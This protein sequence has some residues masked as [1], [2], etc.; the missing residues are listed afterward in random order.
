MPPTSSP[1]L[2]SAKFPLRQRSASFSAQTTLAGLRRE[3]A[4]DIVTAELETIDLSDQRSNASATRTRK[5]NDD[6]TFPHP[7]DLEPRRARSSTVQADPFCA[8]IQRARRTRGGSADLPLITTPPTSPGLMSSER[9]TPCNR[10]SHRNSNGSLHSES[11]LA[12]TGSS[13]S[14]ASSQIDPNEAESRVLQQYRHAL[15]DVN[16]TNGCIDMHDALTDVSGTSLTLAERHLRRIVLAHPLPLGD[17]IMRREVWRAMLRSKSEL[18]TDLCR[19]YEQLVMAGPSKAYAQI[20]DEL[21]TR[22]E[23]TAYADNIVKPALDNDKY[24]PESLSEEVING[25]VERVLN[26]FVHYL[27]GM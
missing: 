5:I 17:R 20:R 24:A 6:T 27:E 16:R 15:D 8:W 3:N 7:I 9:S 18:Y 14:T 26:A 25:I 19:K 13:H 21:T 4:I 23:K 2:P 1:P 22:T 12:S 10:D 11:S